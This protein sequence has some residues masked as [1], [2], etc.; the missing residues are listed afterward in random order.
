MFIVAWM[1]LGLGAGLIGSRVADKRHEGIALGMVGAAVGGFAFQLVGRHG[2]SGFNVWSVFVAGV[3][4]TSLLLS[5]Q[6]TLPRLL[7]SR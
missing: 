6:R 1:M 2:A 3:G 7:G 5:Y 4:A